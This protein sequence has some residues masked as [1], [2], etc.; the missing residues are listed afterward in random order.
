MTTILHVNSSGRKNGSASRQLGA[1]LVEKLMK[2]HPGAS[3]IEREAVTEA[4]FLDEEWVVANFTSVEE[5]SS[6]Q[7][8]RLEHSRKLVEEVQAADFI[9]IGTPIY[10]FTIS[11]V[12]K[13]WIDQICRPG[14][15][16]RAEPD[17]FVGLLQNKKA[18]LVVTSGGTEVKGPIDFATGYMVHVLGFLGIT[19][20]AV[21]AADTMV[22]DPQGA[23]ERARRQ[24]E[25]AV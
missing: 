22:S 19:E 15:T 25:E 6:R 23:L 17:R 18:F 21:I 20:V 1:A 13:A 9:V 7:G 3:V 10:N 16:F 12:L 2:R 11:G 8:K 14:L 24:I 4:E 5:R